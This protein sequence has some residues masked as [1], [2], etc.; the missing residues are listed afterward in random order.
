MLSN[1]KAIKLDILISSGEDAHDLCS[2][3]Y[4]KWHL[5]E[6]TTAVHQEGQIGLKRERTA[7]LCK[8]PPSKSID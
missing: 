3:S 8:D 5:M 2:L 6:H 1:K 7:Y 4:K